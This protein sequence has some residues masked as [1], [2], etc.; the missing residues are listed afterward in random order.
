V[1]ASGKNCIVAVIKPNPALHKSHVPKIK[2]IT[3]GK[4][5]LAV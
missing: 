3:N 4:A 1:A 2:M 5:K